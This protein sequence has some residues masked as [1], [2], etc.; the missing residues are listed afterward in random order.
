MDLITY[1][2]CRKLIKRSIES[3]GDVFTLKGNVDSVG[4]LPSTGNK[5]GDVYLVGPDLEGSYD[6]YYWTS[7][8]EWEIMGTTGPGFEH[9]ISEEAMYKGT[10]GT[11]TIENP[12]QDTIMYVIN[13]N[14]YNMNNIYEGYYYNNKFY[15]DAEHTTEISGQTE[16]FYIDLSTNKIYRWNGT[17]YIE[18]IGD[19]VILEIKEPNDSNLKENSIN[20]YPSAYKP[21]YEQDP[22][23]QYLL[24]NNKLFN[25]TNGNGYT[26]EEYNNNFIWDDI[27]QITSTIQNN[28]FANYDQGNLYNEMYDI[29]EYFID[30]PEKLEQNWPAESG[31]IVLEGQWNYIYDIV[32]DGS[33]YSYKFLYYIDGKFYTCE[34]VWT[35]SFETGMHLQIT[36]CSEVDSTQVESGSRLEYLINHPEMLE[37]SQQV[38][39]DTQ[40]IIDEARFKYLLKSW[41]EDINQD[42]FQSF[43]Q[44]E[45]G[46]EFDEIINNGWNEEN[47]DLDLTYNNDNWNYFYDDKIIYLPYDNILYKIVFSDAEWSGDIIKIEPIVTSSDYSL[48]LFKKNNI[49]YNIGENYVNKT[50]DSMS[51]TLKIHNRYL[52]E[53]ALDIGLD[54]TITARNSIAFGS[55]NKITQPNSMAAGFYSQANGINSLA[56]GNA[57][58]SDGNYSIAEGDHSIAKGANAHAEGKFSLALGTNA[59]AEGEGI[60]N[61]S[62]TIKIKEDISGGKYWILEGQI[63]SNKNGYIWTDNEIDEIREIG[64]DIYEGQNTQY[65]ELWTYGL[66]ERYVEYIMDAGAI[67]KASHVEGYHTGATGIYSHAEGNSTI[68]SGSQSHAEGW[69]TTASG[70]GAHAEGDYTIASGYISHAEGRGTV[71]SGDNSH[72]EGYYAI[73]AGSQT[74]AEGNYTVAYG[75]SA[76]A[77]SG[78]GTNWLTNTQLSGEANTKTYTISSTN[79]IYIGDIVV[80]NGIKGIITSLVK[81]TSITLHQTLSKNAPLENASVKIYWAGASMME[82]KLMDKQLTLKVFIQRHQEKMAPILK[83]LVLL[84]LVKLLMQRVIKQLH[85]EI[86]HMLKENLLP[87]QAIILMQKEL[88]ILKFIMQQELKIQQHMSLLEKYLLVNVLIMVFLYKA[89]F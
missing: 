10:D 56:W 22:R 26:W 14:I 76:H 12:A 69:T 43:S 40:E 5:T 87:L 37:L 2:L 64:T 89:I 82:V 61:V 62:Q 21:E 55:G 86:F 59:H 8:N 32:E 49:V 85:L 53:G 38:N 52:D 41:V 78:G 3:L 15:Q 11:G 9:A 57:T 83:E 77:E 50:G 23:F 79:K 60:S 39:A 65:I 28:I 4:N 58:K 75:E 25:A 66:G 24:Q 74:H 31:N 45:I 73:S 88:H 6:E 19:S 67:G 42:A 18:V 46:I 81:D 84:L 29:K 47:A 7:E 1:A 80:Y 71:A 68:A 63:D 33:Q 36:D 70:T 16:K 20:Y 51:G 35:G 44:S 13:N 34:T 30:D 54:N 48:L 17:E 27:N 72:A